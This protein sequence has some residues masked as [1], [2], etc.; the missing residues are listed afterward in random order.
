M[1][2]IPVKERVIDVEA[3]P[4]P[5][6][7]SYDRTIQEHGDPVREAL[8]EQPA[9]VQQGWETVPVEPTVAMIDATGAV[10]AD[11]REMVV[12]NWK[13]MLAAA[14]QPAQQQEP[15]KTQNEF[16]QWCASSGHDYCFDLN[17]IGEY[18]WA[19]AQGAYEAYWA[20]NTSPPALH[21]PL[22]DEQIQKIWDVAAGAIPGWSRHIAY[23]RAIEA[24]HGIKEQP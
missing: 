24:A 2:K 12:A 15:V 13:E 18:Q 20:R 11:M 9:P 17:E 3:I 5:N 6:A 14:P 21:K 7:S 10:E 16:E 1:S 22:T 19:D 23:A 4:N 8:A